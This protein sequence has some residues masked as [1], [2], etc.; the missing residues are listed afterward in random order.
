LYKEKVPLENTVSNGPYYSSTGSNCLSQLKLALQTLHEHHK[1]AYILFLDLVKA[2]DSVNRELL[3]KILDRYGVPEKMVKVLKKLHNN[4][5]Y[6]MQ[7]G[8]KTTK[9]VSTCGVKQGDNLGPI[10]FIYLIQAVSTTLDK[11]WKFSTPDFRWHGEKTDN[12]GNTTPKYN[13]SLGKGTSHLTQG[14]RF[15]FWKSYYV[16]DA[17]FLFLNRKDIEEASKLLLQHFDRFGY[18]VH[19]DDRNNNEKSKTEVMHIPKPGTK[20]HPEAINDINIDNNKHFSFCNQFNYLGSIFTNNLNDSEDIDR[21]IKQATAAF[22]SLSGNILRNNKIS[23]K[24]RKRTYKAIV[25]N[26]LLWGCE[27]WAIKEK[28][29]QRLEVCLHRC[30]R[31]MLNITIYDVQENHITNTKIREKMNESLSITQMMELRRARLLEK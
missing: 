30:I 1:E 24:L 17:A 25:I 18:T 11:K 28:D 22:A 26:L 3:W 6:I 16:D 9:V 13:P 7:I 5:Q 23:K 15:L 31:R 19:C 21:R 20:S 27:S 10:L 12:N 29:Q 4:V 14:E 8:K 2:Y